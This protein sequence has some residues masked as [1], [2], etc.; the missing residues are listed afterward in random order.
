MTSFPWSV[1]SY[2]PQ[3]STNQRAR[4]R[5]VI[6]KTC[7]FLNRV[8]TFRCQSA[9]K[10][11]FFK[12]IP[13]FILIPYLISYNQHIC[14]V[15]CAILQLTISDNTCMDMISRRFPKALSSSHRKKIKKNKGGQSLSKYFDRCNATVIYVTSFQ[16]MQEWN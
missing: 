3:L 11:I 8:Q 14:K 4:N 15:T 13:P 12:R 7:F 2:Q 16:W 1:L 9:F 6:V 5:S 10:I